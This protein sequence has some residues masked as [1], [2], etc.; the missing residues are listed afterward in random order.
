MFDYYIS[1]LENWAET[2]IPKI[3]NQENFLLIVGSFFALGVV[4]KW[5][6]LHN[7]NKLIRKAGNINKTNNA[8]LRQIKTKYD[9]LRQVNHNMENPIGFVQKSLNRCRIMY[10]SVNRVNNI[11]NYCTLIIMAVYSIV[12]YEVYLERPNEITWVQY[13]IIGSFVAIS[14][15]MVNRTLACSDRKMELTY[16]LAEAL[17]E[18]NG[19]RFNQSQT[20]ENKVAN[21][22][23]ENENIKPDIAYSQ[24]TS[25]KE[26]QAR[27]EEVLDQFIGE[28]L[29]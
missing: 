17:E 20:I 12:S 16:V 19:R 21:E 1:Q 7:Y 9:S 13:L 18:G 11:I 3:V 8:T 22:I 10:I 26:E 5:L 23:P 15:E 28:F 25:E 2:T 27:E 4:T 29:R 24:E 6:V 14:L